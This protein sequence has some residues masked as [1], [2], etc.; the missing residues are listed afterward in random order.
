MITERMQ[1]LA[2]VSIQEVS[3]RERP[4]QTTNRRHKMTATELQ[5]PT[6]INRSGNK[7]TV[8]FPDGREIVITRR[9]STVKSQGTN[10][11]RRTTLVRRPVSVY[12]CVA[13]G[14]H[15]TTRLEMEAE[16][17]RRCGHDVTGFRMSKA[18]FHL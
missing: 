14:L 18:D 8:R 12:D 9:R 4:K 13:L 15:G 11:Q 1:E 2:G 7:Y 10:A 16:I 5:W 17:L 3:T 6:I